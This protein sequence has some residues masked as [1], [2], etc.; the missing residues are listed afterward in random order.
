MDLIN[1]YL[2]LHIFRVNILF[3]V[4]STES[5]NSQAKAIVTLL[6]ISLSCLHMCCKSITS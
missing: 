2:C 5:P 1:G 6:Q 3:I 4:I